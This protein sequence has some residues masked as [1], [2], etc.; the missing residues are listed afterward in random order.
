MRERIER[1]LRGRGLDRNDPVHVGVSGGVDSMVLL[2][3][4][5]ERGHPCHVAH[6][7]HG[8][9][10]SESDGDREFVRDHCLSLGIPFREHRCDVAEEAR[11]TGM[12]KQMAARDLRYRWF[13]DLL[14]EGPCIMALAHHADDAIE[15]LLMGLVQG[16]GSRGWGTIPYWSDAN[17]DGDDALPGHG[18][19]RPL[20]NITREEILAYAH[21]HGVRF[22]E[23]V[24]N[25]DP[26]YTRNRMRHEVLPLLENIRPGA[27]RV[28]HRNVQLLREMSTLMGKHVRNTD[29]LFPPDPT[30][31]IRI[32]LER[33]TGDTT[34]LLLLMHILR[35]EGFH[36]D[37]YQD[38]LSAIESGGGGAAFPGHHRDVYVGD[39]DLIVAQRGIAPRSWTVG[40]MD[41]VPMDAPLGVSLRPHDAIDLSQGPH[42]A[43]FDAEVVGFPLELRPWRS[44]D[45][46]R[47]I[48]LNGSKLVSDI[49]I[50]AKVPRDL[51]QHAHVLVSAGRIVW[52]CGHR[53]AEGTQASQASMSILRVEYRPFDGVRS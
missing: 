51:K 29:E 40:S 43:W 7:D 47:P 19:V 44:G 10:G 13:R 1:V 45:R 2:H 6:V 35:D 5:L 53:L 15:T 27:R 18:F 37:R 41:D 21:E 12:S 28:L 26:A 23:D 17:D 39:R 48:G 9:R 33:I 22:R 34:P 3:V 32:P 20:L 4:L 30:G 31:A 38:I 8:L 52:L 50:D 42:V 46:L 49:L 14:R 11:R 36:P 24:S 25:T 16:M